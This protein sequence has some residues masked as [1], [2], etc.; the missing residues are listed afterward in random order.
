MSKNAH[1]TIVSIN[2]FTA[3]Y[4]MSTIAVWYAVYFLFQASM[5]PL[6]CV[7]SEPDSDHASEWLKDVEITKSVL[8]S[9]SSENQLAFT[10]LGV[11]EKFMQ[12]YLKPDMTEQ[13][14][15]QPKSEL[16][17]DLYSVFCDGFPS[18][19]SSME[20]VNYDSVGLSSMIF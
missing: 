11:I 12:Q 13:T 6:I 19:N 3:N 5:M 20:S 4:T 10:F 16:I 18:N 7:C 9:L 15:V 14:D 17:T 8:L 1:E 2:D